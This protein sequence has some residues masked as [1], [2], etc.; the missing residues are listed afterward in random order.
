MWQVGHG[1]WKSADG[2]SMPVEGVMYRI[3]TDR[4]QEGLVLRIQATQVNGR[5]Y[6]IEYSILRREGI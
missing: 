5:Y 1:E 3:K 2:R 4:F 6:L